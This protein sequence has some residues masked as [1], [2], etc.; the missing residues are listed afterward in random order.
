[1]C[2]QIKL[3]KFKPHYHAAK[4]H[5]MLLW[6][7]ESNMDEGD[8]M[9]NKQKRSIISLKLS[10]TLRKHR[11]NEKQTHLINIFQTPLV[12]SAKASLTQKT[13]GSEVS[14]CSCQ[15][16]EW[17]CLSCNVIRVPIFRCIFGFCGWI[18]F[19]LS[20]T[21]LTSIIFKGETHKLQQGKICLLRPTHAN[22]ISCNRENTTWQVS[23]SK[24]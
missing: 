21:Q 18:P 11:N 9:N 23:F 22:A 12:Y 19:Q 17:E 5:K 14:S 7:S 1:M 13:F 20:C 15:L 2:G 6:L 10:P 4:T 3:H 8:M 16:T 24:P